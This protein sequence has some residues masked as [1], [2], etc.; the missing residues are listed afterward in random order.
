MVGFKVI[1]RTGE[2]VDFDG[3]RIRN[4]VLKAIE[5]TGGDVSAAT[6]DRIVEDATEELES[7]FTD[8]FP[9][10]ENIQDIVEKHLV[11]QGLYEISK[12][13]I[14]Y[15]AE[16]QKIRQEAK[17]R[18]IESA[19]L[20][21]LTVT[22][23]DGRTA[24]FNVKR[25]DDTIKRSAGELLDSISSDQLIHEVINNV[26]DG[27]TTEGIERALVLAATAFMEKDP[28]YGFLAAR[29]LMQRIRK[30]VFGRSLGESAIEGAHV[31]HLVGQHRK[32][33]EVLL[34]DAGDDVRVEVDELPDVG[35]CA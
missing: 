16:R 29:F 4:A 18:A 20:G 24:L 28:A 14:L 35:G 33:L 8:F 10:V 11:R 15:R 31:L 30:E 2:V 5:A 6:V 13:Y 1:K 21:K 19:R 23:R 34:R 9:N 26:Y 17:E 22:K 12:A 7:R 27:I 25:I 32:C 3:V